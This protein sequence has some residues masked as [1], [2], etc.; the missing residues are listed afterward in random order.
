[1]TEDWN[2]TVT[3]YSKNVPNSVDQTVKY[4]HAVSGFKA[5]Q[6]LEE[7]RFDGSGFPNTEYGAWA[8]IVGE[9]STTLSRP[10]IGTTGDPFGTKYRWIATNVVGTATSDEAEVTEAP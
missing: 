3:N 5:E 6:R 10:N 9:T 4:I 2:G 8:D 7:I 1:M